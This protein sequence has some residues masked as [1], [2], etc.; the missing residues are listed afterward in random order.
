MTRDC[1]FVVEVAAELPLEAIAELL[2]VPHEDRFKLFDW[3][4]RMIAADDHEY[5]VATTRSLRPRSRCSCTPSP[6]PTAASNRSP[7]S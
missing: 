5:R 7:T 3:S 2:G 1:D 4:N 6:S